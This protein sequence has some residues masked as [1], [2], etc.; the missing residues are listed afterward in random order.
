MNH[1]IDDADGEPAP[2]RLST[3]HGKRER[4]AEALR[5]FVAGYAR[6]RGRG[7]RDP[8]DRR[9]DDDLAAKVARM[10]PDGFDALL[11]DGDEA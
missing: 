10:S 2:P 6:K 4:R 8:N 1:T 3:R 11:R 7:G 9:Y 5:R